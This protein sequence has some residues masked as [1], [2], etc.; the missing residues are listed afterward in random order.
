MR[1]VSRILSA[2][3][4]SV[5]FSGI[6]V[7]SDSP[8]FDWSRTLRVD[9]VL[10][11][12]SQYQK[13]YVAAIKRYTGSVASPNQAVSPFEYG[14]YS[15]TL[16]DINTGDT[17]FLRSFS[18]LF[19]EW[20]TLDEAKERERAF[21]ETI[22][23]PLP[24][25][26]VKLAL[27]YRRKDGSPDRLIDEV[28]DSGNYFVSEFIPDRHPERIIHKATNSAS[29]NFLFLAEGYRAEEAELFYSDAA[30]LSQVLLDTE[31]YKSYRNAINIRAIAVPSAESGYDDPNQNVWK[32]TRFS[33]GFNT[34][35]VE[36]YLETEACWDIYDVAAQ[37]PHDHIILIVN[38]DKYGGGGV[39]NH[40]SIVTAAHPMSGVV[41]VHEM[42]HGF[43]GLGDEYFNGE[44]TYN[45]FYNKQIEP[46]QPNLTTLVDFDSKWKHLLAEDIPVPTP[47]RAQ[48]KN[49]TAVF[50]G[51][52]YQRKGV[53]R[54]AM[55][56][57]MRTNEAE[58]F[59]E[60]CKEVL[61]ASLE[62]FSGRKAI[63]DY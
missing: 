1:V 37:A 63:R 29:V 21:Q 46:R 51:G 7:D 18:T 44:S 4:L 26:K 59:C 10:A 16:S 54:P 42:G 50:E 60:V 48:Y 15:F 49:V 56:C 25:K 34:F 28:L 5:L 33:S 38:S 47:A 62:F 9:L 39:F 12:N 55:E 14:D 24:L 36:R 19:E 11:G 22:E 58:G 3:F 17:L 40:F 43:G 8:N 53:Y 27:D 6:K 20:Q 13:A 61:A 45:N 52:G 31:P 30:K 41:L 23:M 2:L 57:R 35:G 32:N